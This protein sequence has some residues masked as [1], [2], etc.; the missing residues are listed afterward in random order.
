MIRPVAWYE[1]ETDKVLIGFHAIDEDN[2]MFSGE[3][4]WS[5]RVE[6]EEIQSSLRFPLRGSA[7][8]WFGKHPLQTFVDGLWNAHIRPSQ[9]NDDRD[10]RIKLLEET[11]AV[12]LDQLRMVNEMLAKQL[13]QPVHVMVYSHGQEAP[14]LKDAIK[15]KPGEIGKEIKSI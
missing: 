3:V 8:D 1:G 9:E 11:N 10:K 2:K 4:S 12:L 5:E 14:D 15:S 7:R 6:G 13:G